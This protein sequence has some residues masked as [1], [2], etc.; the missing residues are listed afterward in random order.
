MKSLKSSLFIS[1][2]FLLFL[3]NYFCVVITAQN[4]SNASYITTNDSDQNNISIQQLIDN[5]KEGDTIYLENKVYHESFIINKTISLIGAQQRQTY[6]SSNQSPII[7]IKADNVSLSNITLIGKENLLQ[8][9]ILFQSS[10]NSFISNNE[11]ISIINNSIIIDD[12]TVGATVKNNRFEYNGNGIFISG[13]HNTITNNLF[14]QHT[15]HG[16]I[17]SSN[18]INNKIISNTFTSNKEYGLFIQNESKNTTVYLN[19]FNDTNPAYNQGDQTKWYNETLSIGNYWSNYQG[20][21]LD[22]DGVGDST[23]RVT[24][25]NSIS[26]P[27]PLIYPM[28]Q[29]EENNFDP[30]SPALFPI[31]AIGVVLSIILLVPIA[32]WWRKNVLNK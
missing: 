3:L 23:Y 31:I 6:V 10:Q 9:G 30:N 2:V 14:Y 21:D 27:Y 11:F 29:P 4:S 8:D 28:K 15:M 12:K 18:S 19:N 24:G 20:H 17:L 32:Y 7:S 22:D 16:V 1:L 13:Q 5:S 25:D 26:D